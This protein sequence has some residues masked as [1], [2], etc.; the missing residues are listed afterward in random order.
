MRREHS[1][2]EDV[3]SGA[4]RAF[5][6]LLPPSEGR[7]LEPLSARSLPLAILSPAIPFLLLAYLARREDTHLLRLLLLPIA[8]ASALYSTF[9]Y[10][11][12][13]AHY[14]SF[15]FLRFLVGYYIIGKSLNF[16]L[17]RDGRFKA[18]EKR[19]KHVNEADSTR[20]P[21]P[22]VLPSCLRDALELACTLRGV[23][24]DFGRDV[25]IPPRTRSTQ[26]GC[27]L[28]G[29]TIAILKNFL[30][31]DLCE[32]LIKLVPGVGSLEGGSLFLPHLPLHLRYCLSM[33]VHVLGGMMIIFGLEAGNDFVSLLAVGLFRAS[34]ESWF[35]LYDSPWRSTSLHQFWGKGWHQLLRH[36]FLS[37]GGYPGGWLAGQAGM[38]LGTFLASG[39]Y[40]ELAF[41]LSDHRVVLFFVL[42]GVAILLENAYKRYTGRRVGGI[43]GWCWTAIWVVVLGQMCTDA[44]AIGGLPGAILVP[45]KLSIVR[46]L[47]FPGIRRLAQCMVSR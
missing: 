38:V 34:P 8:V 16:A 39:L 19:L 31:V 11:L 30:I 12:E 36:M 45:R 4:S 15:E 13:D 5:Q 17:V 14:R 37:F 44:W 32:S 2:L 41:Q 24:W 33:A 23:G 3:C 43:A 7:E 1:L 6:K 29:A 42:Q 26:R 22:G 9:H 25:Y 35:P 46:S 20:S 27:F 47:L 10:K 40:H 28:A 21:N 18:G